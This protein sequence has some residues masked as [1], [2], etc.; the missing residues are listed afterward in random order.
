MSESRIGASRSGFTRKGP[1]GTSTTAARRL[2]STGRTTRIERLPGIRRLPRRHPPRQ[3]F[4]GRALSAI[5]RSTL[6]RSVGFRS[7]GAGSGGLLL[8][9]RPG[10][11][12]D[13]AVLEK[14]KRDLQGL[15]QALAQLLV[16][17]HLLVRADGALLVLLGRG[18]RI[19]EL[20]AQQVL[21]AGER[22]DLLPRLLYLALEP[23]GL[24]LAAAPFQ[25][26]ARGGQLAF[27]LLRRRRQG[28][29]ALLQRLGGNVALDRL[30]LELLRLLLE[31]ALLLLDV[32]ELLL[33]V[34][35]LLPELAD[36]LLASGAAA[37]R[38]LRGRPWR[39]G[40][41]ACRRHCLAPGEPGL[42]V[43]AEQ[44]LVG[45]RG[46]LGRLAPPLL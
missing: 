28:V 8:R 41:L 18:L 4:D 37:R 25:L 23:D 3:M 15:A 19:A 1:R 17:L 11:G 2:P 7:G 26:V 33:L 36:A 14:G 13:C 31:R 5:A 9:F 38:G 29:R 46:Q 24:R 27:E 39:G 44:L 40:R 32:G 34:L 6:T 45:G 10:A 22:R 20:F 21:L 42:L 43:Q 16:A 12:I 35:Q 30:V